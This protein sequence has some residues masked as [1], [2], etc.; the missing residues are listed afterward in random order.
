V[1]ES[2]LEQA[3]QVQSQILKNSLTDPLRPKVPKKPFNNGPGR[4]RTF[5]QWIMS[6]LLY[7]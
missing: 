1:Q 3:R 6:P 7:R 5:D 2:N 4:D